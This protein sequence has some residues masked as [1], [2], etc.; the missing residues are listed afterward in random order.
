M[1]V[2]LLPQADGSRLPA[3]S[4]LQ[5]VTVWQRLSADREQHIAV[6]GGSSS[7]KTALSRRSKAA[8]EPPFRG[9]PRLGTSLAAGR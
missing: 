5:H 4:R 2:A 9:R 8:P 3:A 1:G 6:F 7:G